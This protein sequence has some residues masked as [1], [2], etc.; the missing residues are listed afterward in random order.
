MIKGIASNAFNPTYTDSNDTDIVPTHEV[1]TVTIPVSVEFV[2]EKAFANSNYLKNVTIDDSN[3]TILGDEAFSGCVN[4]GSV[5][6]TSGN[7]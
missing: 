3:C 6:F 7:S 2:G 1:G 4:L 5:Q